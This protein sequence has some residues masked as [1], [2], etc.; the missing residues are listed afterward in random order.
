MKQT[1]P[2]R[3][4]RWIL[5]A[6]ITFILLVLV[7]P[8]QASAQNDYSFFQYTEPYLPDTT[9]NI[10]FALDNTNFFKNNEYKGTIATGA[11]ILGAWFR[12]KAVYYPTSQL[13][14]ELGVHILK[15]TGR[16]DY[17]NI[18]PWFTVRYHPTSALTLIMGN[19]DQDENHLLPEAVYDPQR[20]YTDKPQG[21]IQVKYET[22]KLY[23]DMWI[24][25]RQMIMEGDPF[26]EKFSFGVMNNWTLFD[27]GT[28]RVSIPLSFFG[29]HAGGQINSIPS[30]VRT[31]ISV[32]P[33]VMF[34]H[35]TGGQFLTDIGTNDNLFITTGPQNDTISPFSKGHAVLLTGYAKTRLGNITAAY[36][37][38]HNFFAPFGGILYQNVSSRHLGVSVSDRELIN[39]K[40]HFDK[41]ITNQTHLGFM[42]DLYYDTLEKKSMNAAGLY[43]VVNF[44]VSPR[45]KL[46]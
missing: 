18:S 45:K 22:E 34:N 29:T 9:G 38:S 26:Q 10:Y 21:G 14:L 17:E 37:R 4:S 3:F 43:L 12:P 24:N 1:S 30:H 39:L 19:L 36:W 2:F 40:Y 33:G 11:T 32:S 46:H 23:T 7:I 16:T 28:N 15:Y 41:A 44:G 20:F 13:R 8:Q 35:K 25:W 6:G 5:P 27:D 42:F 31:Y